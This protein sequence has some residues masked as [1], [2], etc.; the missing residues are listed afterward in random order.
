MKKQ[1]LALFSILMLPVWVFGQAPLRFSYQAVLRSLTGQVLANQN[2]SMRISLLQDSES[3]SAEYVETQNASTNV[4]GLISLQIGGGSV[5]SGSLAS[6][7]WASGPFFI[8]TETD[9]SG[10]S[11]YVLN[12]VSQL[13]SVPYA[14]YAGSA[15]PAPGT[16]AGQML[17]WDGSAWVKINPGNQGQTLTFCDG[18][19]TWGP[20]TGGSVTDVD[21]NTYNTIT[22]GSQV[23]MKENLKVSKY[24]NGDPI[25]EVSNAG[26]WAAIWNNGN[27]TGQAA[28]CY[29][30]NDAVYNTTYG[31]LYNWYAVA[32]PRGLCP[33]GWHV[34]SDAEWTT[35]ENFLGGA[36]VAGGKMK[37]TGTIQASTGLWQDPNT[38][39]TN[40]SGFTAFPG[41]YRTTDGSLYTVGN[42][43]NWWSSTQY[44]SPDAWF[45]GLNYSFAAS[46]RNGYG[47]TAGFSVRC[48]QD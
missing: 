48:L 41:G 12:G 10:G 44:S 22:I 9:P 24:R 30:N 14:L 17:Y 21:G 19:P 18:V 32:D 43:G 37:S 46:V 6:I 42:Y 2:V 25:G 1:I 16:A 35:L 33:T 4:L 36:D 27:P 38:D 13:L 20:C 31:K 29:Y 34:P 3:G 5:Q 7:N 23:W 47:K 40:S 28:W 8:K 11:N 26:Q 45:R 15:N 39:A